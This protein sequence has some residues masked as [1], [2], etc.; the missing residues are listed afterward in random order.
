MKIFLNINF[1]L[2]LSVYESKKKNIFLTILL[3]LIN[4]FRLIKLILIDYLIYFNLN[5]LLISIITCKVLI[6]WNNVKN[7][8]FIKL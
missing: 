5:S 3:N 4:T 1:N 8:K 6:E 7:Y 2:I